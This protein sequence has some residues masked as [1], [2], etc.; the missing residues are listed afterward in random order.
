MSGELTAAAQG[1]RNDELVG[2][3]P[4]QLI[5]DALAIASYALPVGLV[6]GI[7]GPAGG[8]RTWIRGRLMTSP[9]NELSRPVPPPLPLEP[10]RLRRA[11]LAVAYAFLVH[12]VMF[13]AWASRPSRRTPALTRP[14]WALPCW[15]PRPGPSPRCRSRA[16]SPDASAAT[17]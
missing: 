14:T 1:Q 16:C 17:R 6:Y 13:G 8:R 11:R 5:R 2:W 15:P 3:S 9:G 4:R 12:G 7:A 10:A